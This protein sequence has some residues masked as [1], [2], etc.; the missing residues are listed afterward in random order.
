MATSFGLLARFISFIVTVVAEL[1]VF[2]YCRAIL[3]AISKKS[4][5]AGEAVVAF[6]G[7]ANTLTE[8][9]NSRA[10]AGKI[11]QGGLRRRP[12]VGHSSEPS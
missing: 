11:L 8:R 4:K 3:A 7:A 2:S 12:G 6:L 5:V 10:Q 9:L 1:S